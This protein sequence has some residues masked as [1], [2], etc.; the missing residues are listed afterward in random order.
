MEE[1]ERDEGGELEEEQEEEEGEGE[2]R[3]CCGQEHNSRAVREREGR[4][5]RTTKATAVGQWS[6]RT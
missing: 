3:F 6:P 1:D 4:G 2:G 5:R